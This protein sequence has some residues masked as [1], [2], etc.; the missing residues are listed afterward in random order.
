MVCCCLRW[1][2]SEEDAS[3]ASVSYGEPTLQT[4]EYERQR[5]AEHKEYDEKAESAAQHRVWCPVSGS[6]AAEGKPWTLQRAIFALIL[7]S[8]AVAVLSEILTGAVEEATNRLGA[9]SDTF[10]LMLVKALFKYLFGLLQSYTGLGQVFVGACV[11]A[12][13]GWFETCR[14]HAHALIQS[15]G[16]LAGNCAEHITAL[17]M[18][19]HNRMDLAVGVAFGSA[20]Q[21]SLFVMPCLVIASYGRSGPPLI[22]EFTDFEVFC[23]ACSVVLA[24]MVVQV[25][26][27][28]LG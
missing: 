14:F 26:C 17:T 20:L 12:I 2:E 15:F 23:V 8:V 6:T 9:C 7:S 18:A 4:L 19:L 22:L 1:F 16:C 3:S 13:I 10:C 21:I 28:W 25:N 5:L 27:T 24:W 11:V